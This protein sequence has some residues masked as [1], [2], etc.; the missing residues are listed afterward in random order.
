VYKLACP[1]QANPCPTFGANES[2]F[3][4]HIYVVAPLLEICQQDEGLEVKK[5]NMLKSLQVFYKIEV[6][7]K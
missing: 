1:N 6:S 4:F 5:F 2:E 3:L 7:I